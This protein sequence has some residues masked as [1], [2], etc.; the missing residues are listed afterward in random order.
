MGVPYPQYTQETA[1]TIVNKLLRENEV[2]TIT[3][4]GGDPDGDILSLF[5]IGCPPVFNPTY[6]QTEITYSEIPAQLRNSHYRWLR[7]Q[8]ITK[9][10]KYEYTITGSLAALGDHTVLFQVTDGRGGENW[11]KAIISMVEGDIV[12]YLHGGVI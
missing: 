4:V 12:P 2:L 7:D 5:I 9:F 1:P 10:F 8:T 3:L 11:V 6:I